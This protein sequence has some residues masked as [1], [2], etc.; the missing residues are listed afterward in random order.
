MNL[1]VAIQKLLNEI[2]PPDSTFPLSHG[3]INVEVQR[4]DEEEGTADIYLGK[5]RLS[6]GMHL[7]KLLKK[8][9][10]SK[11]SQLR[12]ISISMSEI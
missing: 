2:I 8:E 10:E 11:I 12:S 4:V 5:C 9:L 3:P 7:G 6:E 1:R